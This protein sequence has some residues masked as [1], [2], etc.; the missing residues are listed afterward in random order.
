[1]VFVR[2]N[3]YDWEFFSGLF[4]YPVELSNDCDLWEDE[5]LELRLS[6]IDHLIIKAKLLQV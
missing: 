3:C 1:M 4:E 5:Q 2:D 6:L